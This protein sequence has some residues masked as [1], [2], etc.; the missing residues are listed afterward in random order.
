[1]DPNSESKTPF[2]EA[3]GI[4]IGQPRMQADVASGDSREVEYQYSFRQSGQM[5]TGLGVGGAEYFLNRPGYHERLYTIDLSTRPALEA[6]L[7]VKPILGSS[8]DDFTYLRELAQGL[9]DGFKGEPDGLVNKRYLVF[10]RVEALSQQPI[11]VPA[12]VVPS[13]DG[14][15]TLAEAFVPSDAG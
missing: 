14:T 8:D 6:A 13:A 10:T 1:M 5:L 15:I 4:S 2:Y 9:L 7:R 11:R 3:N 12:G